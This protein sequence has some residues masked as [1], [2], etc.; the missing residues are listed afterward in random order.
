[1]SA[2]R[3]E[4]LREE[5]RPDIRRAGPSPGYQAYALG[6]LVAI[7]V[8]N[9]VDRQVVNILAEPIKIELHLADWQLGLMTGLAFA[10][11][12]TT[13]GLPVAWLA[14]R[15]SRPLIITVAV[16][17]WS[18]CTA[19]CGLAHSFGQLVLARV[20]VGFGEAGGTPPAHSL[21]VDYFP[22]ERRGFALGVY[23]MGAPL[24]GLVGL[25]FGGLVAERFGWRSAF[26]V[27]GAPGLVLCALAAFTLREPRAQAAAGRPAPEEA[28]P[29][30]SEVWRHF[31]ARRSFWFLLIALAFNA[32]FASGSAPFLASYFLR[33]KT[34]QLQALADA[35]GRA[36]GVTLGPLGVLGPALGLLIGVVG[37][38][39]MWTGGVLSDRYALKDVRRYM[40]GPA[41]LALLGFPTLLGALVSPSL[42]VAFL[43]VGANSFV[44]TAAYSPSTTALFSVAAPRMRATASAI[45]LFVANLVG[46]GLGPIGVGALSDLFTARLGSAEGVRFALIASAATALV[47]SVLYAVGARTLPQDIVD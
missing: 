46:L 41:L 7:Y 42:L 43:F 47:A 44:I 5:P 32:F 34:D 18:A 26:L 36:F 35:V 16:L 14:E 28:A 21:I 6:L 1:M 27:A 11:C 10:L 23:G 38:I 22:R 13:L 15:R 30:L 40:H 25:A 33:N 37:A 45:S 29:S 9:F 2:D 3:G 4:M 39:G 12:Y 20:G 24:G 17:V 8:A 19:L 31:K